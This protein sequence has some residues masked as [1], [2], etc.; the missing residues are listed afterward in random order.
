MYKEKKKNK[1]TL[2][3]MHKKPVS[4]RYSIVISMKDRATKRVIAPYVS[5]IRKGYKAAPPIHVKTVSSLTHLIGRKP[6]LL[7]RKISEFLSDYVDLTSLL[8]DT[9]NC[10]KSVTKAKGMK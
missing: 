1:K 8:Q 7:R 10:M 9:A 2:E 3:I 6:S 5:I 4:E